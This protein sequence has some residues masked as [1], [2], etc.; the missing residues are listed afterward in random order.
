MRLQFDR[1][2]VN[3]EELVQMKKFLVKIKVGKGSIK[4][5][6]LFNGDRQLG[7]DCDVLGSS[8][9]PFLTVFLKNNILQLI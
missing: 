8:A 6:N 5:H 1:K 2:Q 7:M 4:L 9:E 3:G